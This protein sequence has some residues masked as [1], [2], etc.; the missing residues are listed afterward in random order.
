MN[1][2]SD[3]WILFFF[4]YSLVL[5]GLDGIG[6]NVNLIVFVMKT[7]SFFTAGRSILDRN[8]A[9]ALRPPTGGIPPIES[10]YGC[11]PEVS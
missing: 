1:T 7:M 8:P 5:K 4:T 10:N 2:E 6:L 11:T 9:G 3:F